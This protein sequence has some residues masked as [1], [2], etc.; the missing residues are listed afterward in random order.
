M[1]WKKHQNILIMSLLSKNI[2]NIS[3]YLGVDSSWW[4]NGMDSIYRTRVRGYEQ[5]VPI[6]Q[7]DVSIAIINDKT[8]IRIYL[9]SSRWYLWQKQLLF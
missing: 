2:G 5:N 6:Q 9:I 7:K 3:F 1:Y 4:H 8:R